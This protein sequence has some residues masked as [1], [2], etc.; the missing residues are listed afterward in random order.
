VTPVAVD[1]A[2]E[3]EVEAVVTI[4]VEA[5]DTAK[6]AAVGMEETTTATNSSNTSSSK[7]A[8]EVFTPM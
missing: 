2:A 7:M 6:E 5:E 3:A 1:V 8:V 4:K